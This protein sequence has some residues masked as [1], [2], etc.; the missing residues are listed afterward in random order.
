MEKLK[1]VE[2]IAFERF[3]PITGDMGVV[4]TPFLVKGGIAKYLGRVYQEVV[5]RSFGGNETLM[6]GIR[7]D[8]E[9]D[10]LTHSSS[11]SLI[12]FDGV[13]LNVNPSFRVTSYRDLKNPEVEEIVKRE[14]CYIDAG[15]ALVLR[16]TRKFCDERDRAIFN[17]LRRKIDNLDTPVLVR[18]VKVVNNQIDKAGYGLRVVIANDFSY[19]HDTKEFGEEE[20]WVQSD[21]AISG[22]YRDDANLYAIRDLAVASRI[23]RVVLMPREAGASDFSKSRK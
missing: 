14:K 2:E 11:L 7:Y 6:S 22:L 9:K 8:E 1:P 20:G 18:G 13:L 19:T 23:G 16:N 21:C 10:A 17:A 3:V 15:D 5:E 12:V 4:K